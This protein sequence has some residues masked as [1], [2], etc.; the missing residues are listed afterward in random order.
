MPPEP[1]FATCAPQ[2]PDVV[3]SFQAPCKI[4]PPTIS[5]PY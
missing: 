4:P 1:Y 5:V 2:E 3:T